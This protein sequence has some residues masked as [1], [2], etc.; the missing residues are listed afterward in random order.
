MVQKNNR[1]K[2]GV[3]PRLD[4]SLLLGKYMLSLFGVQSLEELA[5]NMKSPNLEGWDD[6]NVSY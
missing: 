2:L 4:N 1:L 3:E 6:E 5:S